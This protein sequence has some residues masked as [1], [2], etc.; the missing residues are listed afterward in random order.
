MLQDSCRVPVPLTTLMRHERVFG[1]ARDGGTWT[2]EI[3]LP[4]GTPSSP[5]DPH[6]LPDPIVRC[7]GCK[8]P[9]H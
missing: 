4:R 8:L 3:A 6:L 7:L 9:A 5:L 1:M 2:I